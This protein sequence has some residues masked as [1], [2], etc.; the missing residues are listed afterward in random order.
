M[1]EF[2][3]GFVVLFEVEPPWAHAPPAL[4]AASEG[5]PQPRADEFAK[6]IGRRLSKYF[7][8]NV[9]IRVLKINPAQIGKGVDDLRD[10]GAEYSYHFRFWNQ[11]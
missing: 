3:P 9:T 5:D 8:T 11:D 10:D 6:E 4:L 7:A 2:E 1:L